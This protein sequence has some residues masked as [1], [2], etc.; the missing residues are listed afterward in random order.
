MLEDLCINSLIA[1]WLYFTG[2]LRSNI[3]LGYRKE[4]IWFSCAKN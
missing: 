4:M 3:S 2:D 1:G